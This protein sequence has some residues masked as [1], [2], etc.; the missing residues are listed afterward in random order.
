MH[1]Y[2]IRPIP[3]WKGARD[4]STFTYLSGEGET[5]IIGNYIWYIEGSRPKTIVDAG[6]R[7][8]WF[9][10]HEL[11]V[12]KVQSME[13]GL[14]KYN[15]KPDDIEIVILTHL[16]ADHIGLAGEFKNASFIVQKSELDFALNP[17]GLVSEAYD[18][19][20]FTGLNLEVVDG[21]KEIT[22]GIRVL[23]TPGHTQGGQ[24]IA[25]DTPEG[26]AV[27]SGICVIK[28]NFFPADDSGKSVIPPA[29]YS[30]L[31]LARDSMLR[32]KNLADIIVALHDSEFLENDRI[33]GRYAIR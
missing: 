33:P 9:E 25:V 20:L 1:C 12:E 15:L 3:L 13:E 27:I 14:D 23:L 22:D 32:V 2:H 26:T 30:D 19:Q 6:A 10:S 31:Q 17:Y 24:S 21:D 8:D 16:H 29:R 18:A 11:P 28:E 5:I 4:K 7:F